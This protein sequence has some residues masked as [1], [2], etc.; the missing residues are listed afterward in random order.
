MA[1]QA[2]DIADLVATT[3]RHV[4][5]EKFTDNAQL[6]QKYVAASVLLDKEHTIVEGGTQV[7]F[8]VMTTKEAGA[9]RH[10]GLFDTD[11]VNVSD[12]MKKGNMPWRHVNTAWAVDKHEITMNSGQAEKIV[13]LVQTRRHRALLDWFDLLETDLWGYADATDTKTPQGVKYWVVRNTAE[14]FNGGAQSG[15]SE[16]GGINPTTYARWK[17][18]TAQYV[19]VTRADL[20]TKWKL[21]AMKTNFTSPIPYAALAGERRNGWYMN[22]ATYVLVEQLLEE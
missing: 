8:E 12:G 18:Y 16:V 21:A 9:A 15:Y 2:D 10:V 4:K 11:V 5:K 7:E 22:A 19:A 20:L 17:N 14:G 1:L 3:M 13:N 6:L